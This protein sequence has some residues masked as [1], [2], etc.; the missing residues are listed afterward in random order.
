MIL[1]EPIGIGIQGMPIQTRPIL[2]DI[3]F[4]HKY[5]LLFS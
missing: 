3:N 2:I 1:P 4:K 5:F